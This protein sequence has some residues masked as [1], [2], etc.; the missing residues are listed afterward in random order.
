M[1]Q[2]NFRK[3]LA[4]TDGSMVMVQVEGDDQWWSSGK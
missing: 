3:T 2:M 1:G 4:L